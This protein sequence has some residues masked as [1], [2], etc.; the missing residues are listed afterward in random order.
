M[1]AGLNQGYA[2]EL[3]LMSPTMEQLDRHVT[4]LRASI[5]DKGLNVNAG[6]T[7]L[8]V[9]ISGGKMIVNSGK[10]SSLHS[11][12]KIDSQAVKWCA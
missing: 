4:E 1:K 7:K 9:G 8:M 3:L 5:L 10:W 11:I 6:N 12:Y 2:D